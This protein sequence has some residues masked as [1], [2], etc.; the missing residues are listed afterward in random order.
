MSLHSRVDS[1]RMNILPRFLYLFQC[2]PIW[3]TQKYFDEWDNILAKYIWQNK[4]C[5]IKYQTLQL[6]KEKGGL[7][8][9]CLRDYYYAAQVRPLICLCSPIYSA[10][11]KDVEGTIMK[12]IPIMALLNDKKLQININIT[13]EVLYASLLN[14]WNKI[15]QICN[16]KKLSRT[17][18]WCAYD[19]DF[20]PNALDGRFKSWVSKR[21]T[22]YYSFMHKGAFMSFESLQNKYAL[23]QDDFYRYLQVRHYFE[24]NI[25]ITLDKCNLG[26]LQTFLTL[27]FYHFR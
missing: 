8:L 9:P 26:L 13:E 21:I 23:G 27:F 19:S 6:M 16:L 5:R 17:L 7:G 1:I 14:S 12:D 3:I 10:G 15:L 18:R 2:L 11:W 22:T 25:K 24:Q 20:R 4:R